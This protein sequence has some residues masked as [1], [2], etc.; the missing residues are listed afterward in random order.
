V[1][2]P[3]FTGLEVIVVRPSEGGFAPELLLAVLGELQTDGNLVLRSGVFI[4]FP[5]L[6][7]GEFQQ[8]F[9]NVSPVES[10]QTANAIEEAVQ[11]L[12]RAAPAWLAK[13]AAQKG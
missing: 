6:D 13:L 4:D 3:V 2:E 10:T 12:R 1:P 8:I 11:A 9:E 5:Q 7:A